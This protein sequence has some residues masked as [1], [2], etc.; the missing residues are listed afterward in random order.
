M[1]ISSEAGTREDDL[2]RKRLKINRNVKPPIPDGLLSL[3]GQS[4]GKDENAFLILGDY[5]YLIR[6]KSAICGGA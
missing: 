1:N 4:K 3:A 6:R 5:L 2:G